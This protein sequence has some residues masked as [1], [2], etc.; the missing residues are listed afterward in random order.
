MTI[1][2]DIKTLIQNDVVERRKFVNLIRAATSFIEKEESDASI[3][4]DTTNRATAL[5]WY[6]AT[7]LPQLTSNVTTRT[8]ALTNYNLIKAS[9]P[10]ETDQYRRSI[11]A[12]KLLESEDKFKQVKASGG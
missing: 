1:I 3:A 9:I 2:D 8:Q 4:L 10:V 7:I 12:A 6:N 5:T 11:L